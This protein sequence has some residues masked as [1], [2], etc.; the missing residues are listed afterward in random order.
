MNADEARRVSAG[1]KTPEELCAVRYKA[2]EEE[3]RRARQIEDE[4][5]DKKFA[6]DRFPKL[7]KV[8][9]ERAN[10]GYRSITVRYPDGRHGVATLLKRMFL[11]QGF[12]IDNCEYS[13]HYIFRV[14]W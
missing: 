9:E 14:G 8:L 13:E 10:L 4:R 7:M 2:A 3:R 5:R 1:K 11:E 6:E 12:S